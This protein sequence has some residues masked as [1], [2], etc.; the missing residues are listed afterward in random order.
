MF[1]KKGDLKL[2]SFDSF[3]GPPDPIQAMSTRIGGVSVG[4]YRSLNLGFHVDDET[5]AVLINR[6]R[7]CQ[8]LSIP[9]RSIVTG[10]Q[11]HGTE[12]A[13]V[14]GSDRGKGARSWEEGILQTD[15]LVTE[16]P[17]VALMVLVADCAAVLLY[18]PVKR[19]VGIAHGSWRGTVGGIGVRTVQKMV[20]EFGCRPEEIQA[21]ISPSIGP[22]CY[23]VGE[24]VIS[25]LKGSFPDQWE[26][27]I[28]PK[29]RGSVHFD[30]WEALRG[31][32]IETGM[33]EEKIETAGICTACHTDLFYS[34][35]GENGRTGRNGVVI[36]L[37]E[38]E[39][40]VLRDEEES[41]CRTGRPQKS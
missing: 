21:G 28:V 36:V 13:V 2:F 40:G 14:K 10:Q 16:T 35:R 8:A 11:V 37:Q 6:Q 29:S 3:G 25:A 38:P 24:E 15:A 22:C 26:R 34:H 27:Y 20:D 1:Q 18:D 9:L 19:A 17:D 7:F 30:L 4:V 33:R 39:E 31:Q 32:L 5:E 12:V 23:Q 41:T